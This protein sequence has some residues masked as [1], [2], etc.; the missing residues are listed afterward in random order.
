MLSDLY[1]R[2]RSLF[3][4]ATVNHELDEELH[5]HLQQQVDK[6][7]QAG[8]TPEEATRR[9]QLE[10]GG[11]DQIKV[12]CREARGVTFIET[13]AQDV[14]YG[15]RMLLK[16]P[17]FTAAVVLTLALGIGRTRRSSAW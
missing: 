8:L 15:L 16:S 2:L 4:R 14:R 3:R 1:I 7:V 6:Y 11:L 12:D 9:A 13:I 17:G 10:F 5:F